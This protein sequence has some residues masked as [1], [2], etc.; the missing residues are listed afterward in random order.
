MSM[1]NPDP[2]AAANEML[3][4]SGAKSFFNKDTPVGAWVQGNIVDSKRAQRTDYIS[5][6]PKF[7]D[8]GDP[9]MQLVLVI[10]TELRDDGDDDGLRALY[11]HGSNS[12]PQSGL[13]ALAAAVKASGGPLQVGGLLRFTYIGEGVATVGSPPK[14]WKADYAPPVINLPADG[15]SP[16]AATPQAPAPQVAQQPVF[17]QPAQQA[18]PA[19]ASQSV[20]PSPFPAQG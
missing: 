18:F 2:L 12:N 11:L 9:M 10:Q 14:L 16:F 15:Q 13:G 8:N 19:P 3:S 7:W 1:T 6:Q 20:P 4:G 5:K 17:Q